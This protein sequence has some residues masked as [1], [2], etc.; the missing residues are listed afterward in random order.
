MS[1]PPSI[2]ASLN[3][4]A[5]TVPDSVVQRRNLFKLR[6][7]ASEISTD[8]N[9][10]IDFRLNSRSFVDLSTFML[11]AEIQASV[12][13]Q[14][15]NS[16]LLFDE[17][18]VRNEAGTI[19]ERLDDANTIAQI[20]TLMHVSNQ[21]RTTNGTFQGLQTGGKAV[22]N[23]TFTVFEIPVLKLLGFFRTGKIVRPSTFGG[24]HI[25]LRLADSR[26]SVI[27]TETT[28]VKLTLKNVDLFYDEVMVTEAYEDYYNN[29]FDTRGFRMDII[30]FDHVTHN[31]NSKQNTSER[32]IR[33]PFSVSNALA[34]ITVVRPDN[35][36]S[37]HLSS[38]Q[39]FMSPP[40]GETFHYQYT[41]EGQRYPQV[42]VENHER[43]YQEFTK[44][45]RTYNNYQKDHVVDLFNFT[46]TELSNI[47]AT[48]TNNYSSS[49]STSNDGQVGTF[50][51]I[52]H[53]E[54]VL[55]DVYSGV[56]LDSNTCSLE[57]QTNLDT[58]AA[59][60]GGT[61]NSNDASGN[62]IIGSGSQ[63]KDKNLVFDSFVYYTSSVYVLNGQVSVSK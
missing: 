59:G 13:N 50:M 18:T 24:L 55:G 62:P 34:L 20:F 31:S 52:A 63:A 47:S 7:T 5:P 10:R 58:T 8:G 41:N 9:T 35:I 54:R 36:T 11:R 6:N 22:D 51:M 15:L 21:Y 29:N 53:L 46:T 17:I 27:S 4:V 56:S 19:I 42:R 2:P 61:A 39:H 3:Y 45:N 49:N 38:L 44:C 1:A 14:T 25:Q 16:W 60:K 26:K 33:L 37:D 40:E 57:V 12:A 30:T 43:A 23:T 28:A 48:S 32:V